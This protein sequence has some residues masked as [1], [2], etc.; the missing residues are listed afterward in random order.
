[1]AT[2]VDVPI[3]RT[4]LVFPIRFRSKDG[5][6]WVDPGGVEPAGNF[7]GGAESSCGPIVAAGRVNSAAGDE[8]RP[9]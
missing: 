9:I 3:A 2:F 5:D 4:M 7:S 6:A 1:L 8:R